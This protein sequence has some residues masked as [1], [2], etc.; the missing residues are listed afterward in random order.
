MQEELQLIKQQ[1][2]DNEIGAL[3]AKLATLGANIATIMDQQEKLLELKS[4]LST[5]FKEIEAMKGTVAAAEVITKDN[6]DIAGAYPDSTKEAEDLW[7][8]VQYLSN[9]IGDL[10][11]KI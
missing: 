5:L 8:A 2:Q 11:G 3:S 6:E 7:S 10:C 9:P 4:E 1:L